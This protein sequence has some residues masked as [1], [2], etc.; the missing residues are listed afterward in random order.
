MP[1]QAVSDATLLIAV[2]GCA[3]EDPG[4]LQQ[5]LLRLLMVGPFVWHALIEVFTGP[6]GLESAPI[7]KLGAKPSWWFCWFV[8]LQPRLP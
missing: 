5:I 3:V 7:R 8:L 2:V 6:F 1:A 4:C